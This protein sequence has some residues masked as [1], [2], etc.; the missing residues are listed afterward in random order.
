MTEAEARK[1]LYS[2]GVFRMVP[3]L[4]CDH[5]VPDLMFRQS[6]RQGKA[7]P[8][9]YHSDAHRV[10]L[11]LP[12]DVG[13]PRFLRFLEQIGDE[14]LKHFST[15]DFL[16]IDL[17]HRDEV[18]PEH[19]KDRVKGLLNVGVIERSGRGK[20]ILSRKFYAFLGEKGVH[21]RKKGLDRE[22]E[23]ELLIKHLKTAGSDGAP[24]NEFLQVLPGKNRE[25]VKRLLEGLRDE[26]RAH[27]RGAKRAAR[28]YLGPPPA[29]TNSLG[30]DS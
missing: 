6:I 9:P 8:D 13:D 10:L 5:N 21:T 4:W 30:Q 27:V 28:W 2:R 1:D 20:V 26:E 12:G 14:Q 29:G 23:K 18:V 3:G 22:T 24:M 25:Q 17:V 11:R 16:V 15:D 7:L 19:L